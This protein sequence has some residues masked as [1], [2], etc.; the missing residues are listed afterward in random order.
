MPQV[1]G[2]ALPAR[3][4]GRD[5]RVGFAMLKDASRR[6]FDAPAPKRLPKG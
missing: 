2:H 4:R 1:V 5:Q 3:L 6:K